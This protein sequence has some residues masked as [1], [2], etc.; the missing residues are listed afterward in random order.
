MVREIG[1]SRGAEPARAP[2]PAGALETRAK[3]I[4]A[5]AGKRLKI[6][7]KGHAFKADMMGG[8]TM[9]TRLFAKTPKGP[10]IR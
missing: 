1:P 10:G 9:A 5:V 3:T 2:K 8:K 7:G 6:A 4:G